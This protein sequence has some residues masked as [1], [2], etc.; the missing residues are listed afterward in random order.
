MA[1]RREGHFVLILC[2][3]GLRGCACGGDGDRSPGERPSAAAIAAAAI[4]AALISV[5]II[6]PRSWVPLPGRSAVRARTSRTPVASSHT[7]QAAKPSSPTNRSGEPSAIARLATPA[8]S[9]RAP[10]ATPSRRCHRGVSRLACAASA[11]PMNVAPS[12]GSASANAAACSCQASSNGGLGSARLAGGEHE[13][14]LQHVDK[15]EDRRE[16]RARGHREARPVDAR[17]PATPDQPVETGHEHEQQRQVQ[18]LQADR[19]RD[20]VAVL[21]VGEH[22]LERVPVGGAPAT[23]NTAFSITNEAPNAIAAAPTT[24]SRRDRLQATGTSSNPRRC[25]W[26]DLV[27]VSMFFLL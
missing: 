9:S 12:A 1:N 3:W 16:G 21:V 8:A 17:T 20:H 11:A 22:L 15:R 6:P 19:D 10:P 4:A 25:S 18:R 13:P 23:P 27:G 2:L 7:S 14:D 5:P 26:S 24:R